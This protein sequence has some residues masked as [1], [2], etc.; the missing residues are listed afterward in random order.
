MKMLE[1]HQVYTNDHLRRGDN[2]NSWSAGK[3][4]LSSSLVMILLKLRGRGGT[5]NAL[6]KGQREERRPL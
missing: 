2:V 1:N 5:W 6:S 3:G 4:A